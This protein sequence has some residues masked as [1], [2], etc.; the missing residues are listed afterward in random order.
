MVVETGMWRVAQMHSSRGVP[1][2]D[3]FGYEITKGLDDLVSSLD[4]HSADALLS[5]SLSGTVTLMFTDI[6]DSTAMS[7]RLG[8]DAWSLLLSEHFSSLHHIVERSAGT[9][10]K[11]LGD[12]AMIVFPAVKEALSAAIDLQ[13]AAT[14]TNLRIRIGV[15]TGDAVHTA[16]DYVGIAVNKAARIAS[17]A[18]GGEILVSS[19]TAEIAGRQDFLTGI[20]R[21]GELKGLDGTHRL[22]PILWE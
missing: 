10:V 9:V 15:H 3:S 2:A 13:R 17:A 7:E 5:T 4:E 12:G 1:N 11:T 21:V 6:V 18:R 22:I 8:D 14:A 20:E 19:A 16:G